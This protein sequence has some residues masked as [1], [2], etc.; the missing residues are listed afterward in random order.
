[1]PKK[2]SPRQKANRINR[3]RW[4]GHSADG[5][6]RLQAQAHLRQ[7][8]N[9]STGPKTRAGKDISRFNALRHAG[10]ADALLP[11]ACRAF[12]LA[13]RQAEQGLGAP[14]SLLEAQQALQQLMH[15]PSPAALLRA[16]RLSR[17]Y[18]SLLCNGDPHAE[19]PF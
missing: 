7:P 6:L 17:R 1:M 15:L 2:L 12:I 19:R 13:L 11:E 4:V 9:A 16:V 18:E 8:W 10:R 14:P 5:L 3:T